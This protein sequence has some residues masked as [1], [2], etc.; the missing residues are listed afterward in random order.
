MIQQLHIHNYAIINHLE[1]H[2]SPRLNIITGETGAGKSIIMGALSLILGERAETNVLSN[3]EKKCVVEAYFSGKEEEVKTF[4]EKNEFEIEDVLIVRREIAPNGK[5][6]AFIND[7]PATVSQLK[8][9]SSFLVDAHQQFD[10]LEL[11]K[12]DFQINVLD[13]LA[14]NNKLVQQ[15]QSI[16]KEYKTNLASLEQLKTSQAQALK[17]ADYH[18]FL[19]DELNEANFRE[20][21]L[22]QIE[23]DLKVM[24][25]AENIKGG[26]SEI[27]TQLNESDYPILSQLSGVVGKLNGV[28]NLY[29]SL[30][31]VFER[32]KSVEIELEDI[33]DEIVSL[34][35][36]INFDPE[37]I[38]ALNDRM[39]L[40]YSLLKKHQVQ[41]TEQLIDIK[42]NLENELQKVTDLS[43]EIEKI[44]NHTDE[45]LKSANELAG[46]ISIN[47]K[48]AATTFEKKVNQLLDRV[49]MPNASLKVSLERAE[50]NHFGSD[51]IEFL[52]DANK[53]NNHEPLRKVASGGELSRI[54]L[55]IKSLVAH[56][57]QLPTLIFDEIDSGISGEAA[58]QVGILMKELSD[59]HQIISITHQAQIAAKAD[60]HFFVFKEMQSDKIVTSI[61]T[62]NEEERIQAIA[63][64]LSGQKPTA[65]AFQNAREMIAH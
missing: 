55:S 50:L 11:N 61:K 64:M 34:S 22:E 33:A 9:L 44:K 37:K 57:M 10:T 1:I 35:D 8:Q 43:S 25:E 19:F 54:M 13:A 14:E 51:A 63:T 28:R 24:N 23:E 18:Q 17:E 36:K 6:R 45:L 47:R 56:S 38:I 62:L 59:D 16:F 39:A 46:K 52:F 26:L 29:S 32:L 2:F 48:K 7:S 31:S 65:A 20:G 5:S 58:R 49:G 40:G 42:K 15:Y 21:E 3:K 27:Y 4:L 12:N 30:N 41:S 60:A 53:T